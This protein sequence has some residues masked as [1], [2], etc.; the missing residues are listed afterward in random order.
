M[1]LII[2]IISFFKTD[3]SMRIIRLFTRNYG[4][5]SSWKFL[6]EQNIQQKQKL[7]EIHSKSLHNADFKSLA[8]IINVLCEDLSSSNEVDVKNFAKTIKSIVIYP[9]MIDNDPVIME[10]FYKGMNVINSLYENG[11]LPQ[12][13]KL[14]IECVTKLTL[15]AV[16]M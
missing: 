10:K 1:K 6:S 13:T 11:K 5:E 9:D 15:H 16:K 2:N 12:I 4:Y 7:V 3:I 14:R 8:K